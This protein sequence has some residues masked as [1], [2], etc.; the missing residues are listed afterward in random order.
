MHR[1]VFAFAALLAIFI[2]IPAWAQGEVVITQAKALAGNV[3]PGDTPG[4]PIT[5]SQPG[6]YILGSNL[7]V[8]NNQYGVLITS[9]NVDIDL[10]GFRIAGN[11]L[12]AYGIISW[13]SEGR[14][15]GGTINTMRYAGIYI[16]NHAWTIENMKIVRN[17]G[18]GIDATGARY[19]SVSDSLIASN[20]GS[21]IVTGGNGVFK[22][23][24][25]SSNG[26]TGINCAEIC[27]AESNVVDSN[28]LGIIFSSGFALGNTIANNTSFGIFDGSSIVNTGIAN[29]IIFGNNASGANQA[30]YTTVVHPNTCVGKPC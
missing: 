7:T 18:S 4:Y 2:A 13:F 15:H 1:I 3:T 27:H 17:G 11:G 21:G 19:I 25:I 16:R 24:T 22:D 29:N 12:G 5:L 6:A 28:Q 9:N 14:I 30:P 20:L 10:N 26:A 23:S 8:A